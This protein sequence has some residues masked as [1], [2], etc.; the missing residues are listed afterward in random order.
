MPTV[1]APA[2]V[3]LSLAVTGRRDDG[4][5]L[6]DSVVAFAGIGD[7]LDLE[8]AESLTLAVDGPTAPLL[9]AGE[10]NIVL[11]AARALADAAGVRAAASLRLTTRLPVAAGIG[12]GS[13]DAAAAL[14]GLAALWRL[15]VSAEDL[16]AVGVRLGAD[17][18]VCLAGRACRMLGIGETLDA[19]PPLPSAWLVLVNPRVPLAT[20]AVFKARQGAFSPPQPF[21]VPEGDARALAAALA[22]RG[23]DLTAAAIS[24]VPAVGVAL[25][26]LQA[27]A[28]CLLAR[29]S[30][31]GATCFGLF[32]G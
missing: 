3:N 6:L 10:D 5:H 12:G 7:S 13:A 14:K 21:A 1:F 29:M 24:L 27:R 25:A 31:S 18:P 8:A 17:V 26:D 4:Y 9:P 16:A 22:G 32:A 30:G 20:P 15:S 2:K 23:N 19:L 11:K 28:G